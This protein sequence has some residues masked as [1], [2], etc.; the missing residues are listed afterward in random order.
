MCSV[1]ERVGVMV[2]PRHLR[3]LTLS[4]PGMTGGISPG[5]KW[6]LGL[7]KI[8]SNV[9]LLLNLRLLAAAQDSILAISEE[10]VEE[11]LAGT[12]K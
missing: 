3:L 5:D 12:I 7:R 1:N 10:H 4:T 8:I 9:L 6:V 11:F 2:M